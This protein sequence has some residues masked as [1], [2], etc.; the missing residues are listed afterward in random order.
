[1][2]ILAVL[3]L[4]V[5]AAFGSLVTSVTCSVTTPDGT[6]NGP[7][8]GSGARLVDTGF[9]VSIIFDNA[10]P[11]NGFVGQ[12]GYHDTVSLNVNF[13]DLFEIQG[14]SSGTIQWTGDVSHFN[15]GVNSPVVGTIDGHAWPTA[16]KLTTPFIGTQDI[17]LNISA[18]I[19]ES[20]FGIATSPAYG[21][22][23]FS[24]G[25]IKVF[26]ANGNLVVNPEYASSS[27]YLYPVLGG[28]QAV[29]MPEPGSWTLAAL[30]L[31]GITASRLRKRAQRQ[32]YAARL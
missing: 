23:L 20:I 19:T 8:P 4:A 28:I 7:C 9:G 26:D 6:T 29:H 5:P 32:R 25:Q 16:F 12:P 24:L 13:S 14:I 21:N 15:E 11:L 1:M 31:L 27:G 18:A 17:S 2:R 30:G 3:L 10:A 22:W